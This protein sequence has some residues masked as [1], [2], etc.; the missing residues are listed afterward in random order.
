MIR[1]YLK[2]AF[3]SIIRHKGFSFINIAGLAIG[4]ACCIMIFMWVQYELSYDRH[5]PDYERIYRVAT[6]SR[7]ERETYITA[8]TS[9]PVSVNLRKDIPQIEA[10]TGM[11]RLS[12]GLV[13]FGDKMFYEEGRAFVDEDF[14]RVFNPAFLRGDLAS[15]LERPNTVVL[16]KR[17]AQKYFANDSPLGQT[18]TI[19]TTDFEVTGVI[20]DVPSTTHLKYSMLMSLKT[21]ED[22]YP[23]E[24]W[25][26]SNFHTYTKMK[27][28]VDMTSVAGQVSGLANNY[29]KD[30]LDES[31]ESL[32]YFIQPIARIHL[33]SNLLGETEPPGSILNIYAF[34]AIG[35]LILLIACM[36]FINL[37]TA[38]CAIRSKEVGVRKAIGAQKGQLVWQ[39]LGESFLL[40]FVALFIAIVLVEALIP[41]LNS[42]TGAD[43][44]LSNFLGVNNLVL[45]IG[46]AL[47][48]GGLAGGYPA[49]V[50]T[51]FKPV[52]VLGGRW[53]PSVRSPLLR[54]ILVVGQFRISIILIVCTIV[55]H[56]QL[57]FMK[58]R[59]L[60][61]DRE[62]KLIIPIRG[63]ARLGDDFE[64]VKSEFLNHHAITGATA[65]SDVLGRGIN[66]RWDTWPYGKQ[67]NY[68][69]VVSYLSCDDDFTAEYKIDLVAGRTLLPQNSEDSIYQYILNETAV[70]ALGYSDPDAVLGE[71]LENGR[72]QGIVVG[73]ARDFHYRGL[74]DKIESML[75]CS[76][77]GGFR[78]LSL[79]VNTGGLDEAMAF[80]KEKWGQLYPQAPLDYFF[81]DEVFDEQYRS[82][83]HLQAI[84]SGFAFLGIFIACLGLLALA[85]HTA[86]Q[87]T[88][89]F[90]IRKVLGASISNIVQL[91][92]REFIL[93]VGIASVIAWPVAYF[94]IN[95]WL[96]DFAYR[97]EAGW[98]AFIL[99]ALAAMVIALLTTSYQAVK[100]ALTNP[101]ETLRHE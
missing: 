51:A 98:T 67:Q 46:L 49:F 45:L 87:R 16:T 28:G 15:S 57:D 78:Y 36:N 72:D 59:E 99:A 81:L 4:M 31:G 83:E 92:S 22:A 90:G 54:R 18:V 3:R 47:A 97:I 52:S 55:V 70:A 40:T 39:F 9:T 50:L 33:H 34:S 2:V 96:E 64:S 71:M 11:L 8:R 89:E 30:E 43:I 26:L 23:M 1:N 58:N 42:L 61:F 94:A 75:F 77:S 76:S 84:M 82:E 41:M 21:I 65:S 14:F 7:N 86:D 100:V 74:Q 93:L 60:G 25:F 17:I 95:R 88:K 66:S 44:T 53:G 29:V 69:R 63:G 73:V 56:Q 35:I 80:T 79:T 13:R 10:A 85:A 62:Q 91:L 27:P 5:Y 68:S 32:S 24:H 37:T 20:D 48:V 6:D 12:P 101:T 19:N 38:K